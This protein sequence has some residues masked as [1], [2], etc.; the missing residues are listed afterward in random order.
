V[1]GTPIDA[2]APL[3]VLGQVLTPQAKA[4]AAVL[5]KRPER[6]ADPLSICQPLL[7]G[8]TLIVLGQTVLNT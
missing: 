7:N 4:G 2:D 5:R 6:P 1:L 8:L 3:E